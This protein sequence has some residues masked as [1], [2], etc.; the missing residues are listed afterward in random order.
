MIGEIVVPEGRELCRSRLLYF[1]DGMKPELQCKLGRHSPG[2]RRISVKQGMNTLN[3]KGCCWITS[4]RP[5]LQ[6]MIGAPH[7]GLL[8]FLNRII[9]G[10]WSLRVNFLDIKT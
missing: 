4:S 6:S 8:T 9:L 1:V 10:T 3:M 5:L 2:I 7:R